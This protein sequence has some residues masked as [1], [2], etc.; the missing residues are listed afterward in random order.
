MKKAKIAFILVLC[1]AL[2]LLVIQNTAPV[3]TRFLWF[4]G[5]MPL[6][7]LLFLTV[8]G[9]FVLGLFV[10][11]LSSRDRSSGGRAREK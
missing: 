6:V 4:R 9:G 11:L 5:L 8:A 3:E 10:A 1:L 2:V 7:L